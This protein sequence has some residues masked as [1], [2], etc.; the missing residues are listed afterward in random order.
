M[1]VLDWQYI[2]YSVFL[3]KWEFHVSYNTLTPVQQ[4][5]NLAIFTSHKT[6]FRSIIPRWPR[7][8]LTEKS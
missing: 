1:A 5:Q 8:V 7:D 3:H 2:N 6:K 4:S